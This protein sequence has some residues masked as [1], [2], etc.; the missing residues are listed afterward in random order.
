MIVVERRKSNTLQAEV[1]RLRRNIY[2]SLNNWRG[3]KKRLPSYK[4]A[5]MNFD[6]ILS[7]RSMREMKDTSLNDWSGCKWKKIGMNLLPQ[8]VEEWVLMTPP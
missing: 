6:I 8:K 2:S 5:A 3:R 7:P 4:L 1:L